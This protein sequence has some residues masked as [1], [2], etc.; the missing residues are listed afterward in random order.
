MQDRPAGPALQLLDAADIAGGNDRRT[1][2]LDMG[3]LAVAKLGRQY[4]LQDVVA[5]CRAAADMP[6]ADLPQFEPGGPQ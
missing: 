1:R 4:R 6:F 5:A 2:A 3:E